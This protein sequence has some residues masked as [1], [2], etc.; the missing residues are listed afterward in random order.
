MTYKLSD[1]DL[2]EMR[3]ERN[4]NVVH[5]TIRGKWGYLY[6][7]V[8][9]DGQTIDVVLSARRDIAAAKRLLQQAI[10]NTAGPRRSRWMATQPRMKQLLSCKRKADSHLLLL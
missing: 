7:G 1:P 2:V 10:E 5:T 4:V 9:K 8:D 6:R 3:A